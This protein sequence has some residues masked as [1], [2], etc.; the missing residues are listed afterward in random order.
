M[1]DEPKDM[2]PGRVLPSVTAQPM[3]KGDPTA[4]AM[5]RRIA[6]RKESAGAFPHPQEGNRGTPLPRPSALPQTPFSDDIPEAVTDYARAAAGGTAP[7]P[8]IP[9]GVTTLADLGRAVGVPVRSRPPTAQVDE[10]GEWHPGEVTKRG[11]QVRYS[12]AG[13]AGAVL[14]QMAKS[15]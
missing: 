2:A 8:A 7:E 6:E 13:L 11:P 15:R 3:T 4:A 12:G 1:P 5:Q 9:D 10:E 14:K